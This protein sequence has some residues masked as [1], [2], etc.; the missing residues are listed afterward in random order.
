MSRMLRL[1]LLL[2]CTGLSGQAAT[3]TLR[4]GY[5]E[6]PP[7]IYSNNG[8]LQGINYWLW[9]SLASERELVYEIIPMDFGALLNGLQTGAI[10]MSLNPLTLTSERATH[11]DFTL[12]YYASHSAIAVAEEGSLQ[13]FINLIRSFVNSNFLRGMFLLLV[14]IFMFG[15]LG[16][17]FERRHNHEQFR[18][19]WRGIWDGI[20]WSAVTLTTVGYGDKAPRTRS[21]KLAALAL[22]FGGLLFISGLTASMASSLTIDQL[23]AQPATLEDYKD[24]RVGAVGE[25][26]THEYLR[27]HFFRNL[28]TFPD[29]Q[30]G[31]EALSKGE[32]KA[33]MHD[34]PILR[35]RIDQRQSAH[36]LIVLPLKFDPQ[37]YG[38]GMAKGQDSLRLS[39]SEGILRARETQAWQV[40]LSEY[41]LSDF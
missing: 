12:P 32:I 28:Q 13:K 27:S 21:G 34:E 11:F 7:F 31:L 38:F 20:W 25:S 18:P 41:G 35:H 33:F 26:G 40:L 24:A 3:D 6:A 16:W 8:E 19:G 4:I 39:F 30:E 29:L 5:T 1:L 15:W 10:H 37:F 22:M 14:I 23:A 36:G 17:Y 9:Q 2:A